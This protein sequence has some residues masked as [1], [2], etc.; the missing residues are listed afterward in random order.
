MATTLPLPATITEFIASNRS[1]R[2]SKARLL[3][4]IQQA[5]TRGIAQTQGFH[6]TTAFIVHSCA[7]PTE[8]QKNMYLLPAQWLI[9]ST[10]PTR[11]HSRRSTATA[12]YFPASKNPAESMGPQMRDTRMHA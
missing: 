12:G 11:G 4:A 10:R 6:S 5:D 2:E 9:F 3:L 1:H 8:Q 7:S